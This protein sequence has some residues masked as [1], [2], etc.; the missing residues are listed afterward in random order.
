M[1]NPTSAALARGTRLVVPN[2]LKVT[3]PDGNLN[4]AWLGLFTRMATTINTLSD[5]VAALQKKVG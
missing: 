4:Q 3:G 5:Q 1:A 2:D